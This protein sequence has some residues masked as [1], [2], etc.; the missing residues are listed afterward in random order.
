MRLLLTWKDGD[1]EVSLTGTQSRSGFRN[2]TPEDIEEYK[3]QYVRV[4][5]KPAAWFVE[6]DLPP[7]LK[8]RRRDNPNLSMARCYLLDEK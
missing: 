8:V 3:K 5:G 4:K 1:V 2:L 7:L 6:L